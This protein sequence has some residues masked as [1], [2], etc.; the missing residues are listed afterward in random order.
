MPARTLKE[1]LDRNRVKYTAISHSP[2]Y[3]AQE[4]A[5]SAHIPGRELAKTVIVKLD[6]KMAM[7]VLPAPQHVDLKQLAKAAG[8]RKGELA[9][10]KEFAERFPECEAGAMPPF[11][12]L[13][14]M[15]VYVEESLTQDEQIAFNAGSH[16]EL[17]KLPCQDFLR[18][19]SPTVARFGRPE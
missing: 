18:L 3:T 5:A 11:G 12:N 10:E 14:D 2:Q 15:P 8:A 7:A 19:A 13:Y 1:F 9:G 16:R 17:F 6:G 4:I